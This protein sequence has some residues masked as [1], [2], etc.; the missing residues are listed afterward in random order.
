MQKRKVKQVLDSTK[1]LVQELRQLQKK[2]REHEIQL[3]HKMAELLAIR[4]LGKAIRSVLNVDELAKVVV[5]IIA[6]KL[7]ADVGS[8]MFLDKRKHELKIL[9]SAGIEKNK[10]E[11]YTL[12]V[13]EG[14]AGWCLQHKEPVKSYDMEKD[15][16]FKQ[17]SKRSYRKRE[18]MCAPFISRNHAI[19]VFSIEKSQDAHPYTK[20]DLELL[21]TFV[22]E[23]VASFEN[24]ML[25]ENIQQAYYDTIRALVIAME[26]KDPYMHG[27]GDRVAKYAVKIAKKLGLP[28][29]EIKTINFFSILHDIGKIGVPEEILAKPGKLTAREWELIRKHP[30]IGE[31]I[32][33]PIEFLQ[34]VRTLLRHH[35]EWYDGRGYP[36]K[37]KGENIALAARILSVADAYDAMQSD[38]PYRKALSKEKAL[39]ELQR[40]SGTQFDPEVVK[41]I[42]KAVGGVKI[43]NG[44]F[45]ALR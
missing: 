29:E 10:K 11:R 30:T 21:R 2:E 35:H 42:V 40:A 28:E 14:L 45:Y 39:Q 16:R 3:R 13:G 36:D 34:P 18:F 31:S 22:D 19:G 9:A 24:A 25:F 1:N 27:H 8:I 7:K 4:E 5:K 32:I 6:K 43:N 26:S 44:N 17:T 23:T 37:L 12:K 15:P 20:D 41:A 33:E 38:R